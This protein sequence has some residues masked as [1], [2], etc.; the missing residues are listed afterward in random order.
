MNCAEQSIREYPKTIDLL[1]EFLEWTR[2]KNTPYALRVQEAIA[3]FD[4]MQKESVSSE[5]NWKDNPKNN[6]MT[7]KQAAQN[8][9]NSE[10]WMKV[11]GTR[12]YRSGEDEYVSEEGNE[13]ENLFDD[14][15]VK[16]EGIENIFRILEE[17]R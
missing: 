5:T 16:N 10:G 8:F 6:T 3:S 9:S 11:N 7:L 2:F 15:E 1:R 13:L 12:C 4:N 17:K 14:T